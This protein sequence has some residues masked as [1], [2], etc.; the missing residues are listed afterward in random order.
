MGFKMTS[1]DRLAERDPGSPAGEGAIARTQF[2]P[3]ET[4]QRFGQLAGRSSNRPALFNSTSRS[5]P[6]RVFGRKVPDGRNDLAQSLA[7]P[8]GE[9]ALTMMFDILAT[10]VCGFL[11]V[12]FVVGVLWALAIVALLVF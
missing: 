2:L 6:A 12:T 10:I 3:P 1:R 4:D 5:A 11:G 7:P 9:G 8:F